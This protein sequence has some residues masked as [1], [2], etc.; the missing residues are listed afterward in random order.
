LVV[1]VS[2]AVA[3]FVAGCADE[4]ARLANMSGAERGD[5]LAGIPIEVPVVDGDVLMGEQ[6]DS[7]V[8]MYQVKVDAPQAQVTAW[9]EQAYTSANWGLV[10]R[11][12]L[13]DKGESMVFGK[14]RSQ[15]VITVLESGEGE[16]VANGVIG[17]GV[18]V[19]NTY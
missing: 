2:L 15:S 4:P 10:N 17:I 16:S 18:Q 8:W 9:Y 7:D 6:Q 5:D 3:L 1:V 11:T 12:D 13:G 19:G 14:G